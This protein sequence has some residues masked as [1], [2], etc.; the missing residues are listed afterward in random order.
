MVYEGTAHG[1]MADFVG[2]PGK[3]G[4]LRVKLGLS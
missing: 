3:F 2:I 4:G 1:M